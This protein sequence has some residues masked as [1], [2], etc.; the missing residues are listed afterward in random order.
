MKEKFAN[1]LSYFT[2][3][4][5][6]GTKTFSLYKTK[7]MT[8]SVLI[9]LFRYALLISVS[10]V[11]LYP[12]FYMIS[13][14]VKD[15]IDWYDP[16]VF[17]IP[18]HFTGF[19]YKWAYESLDFLSALKNTIL[20][21]MVAAFL[22]IISCSLAAYGL[23]RFKF[24]GKN[25]LMVLLIL[26]ILV[27]DQMIIIPKMMNFSNL[28]FLGI[29]SLISE[30]S[31][32]AIRINILNTGFVFYLPSL[33]AIGLRSGII[34]YIYMQFY[35]GLPRE[36]EEAAWIDGAGLFKTYTKIALPSSGVVITTVSIFSIIWHWNDYYLAIMLMNSY[37]AM[38]LAVRLSNVKDIMQTLYNVWGGYKMT[39]TQCA[40]CILFITPM[41][42]MYIFLQRKFVKSID[43][44]GITG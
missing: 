19:W 7:R 32:T 31:G 39:A 8:T 23:A 3:T 13:N 6:D 14:S 18:K 10:Y 29:V 22:E 1:L 2:K 33:F 27:P 43:R 9:S 26:T 20:F 42:I 17:W 34:I 36:L 41:L 16:N 15:L 28:D 21:E 40:C 5:S 11:V 35:K 44:V 25:I 38:P 24:K 37:N 30:V 4:S 12:L